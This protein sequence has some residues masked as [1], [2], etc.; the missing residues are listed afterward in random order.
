MVLSIFDLF[1]P[2]AAQWLQLN[3][4][5]SK[6]EKTRFSGVRTADGRFEKY[7]CRF[8][9]ATTTANVLTSLYS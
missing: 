1:S 6:K 3:G 9:P 7:S 4:I 8:R 2:L 5:Y